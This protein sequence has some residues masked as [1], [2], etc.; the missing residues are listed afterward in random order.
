[1]IGVVREPQPGVDA[2]AYDDASSPPVDLL[3]PHY[4]VRVRQANGEWTDI[5]DRVTD[6]IHTDKG[7]G[8]ATSRVELPIN[9]FDDWAL[10]EEPILRKGARYLVQYGYPGRMREPAEFVAKEHKGNSK[11]ITVTAYER[12]RAKRSRQPKSR[13]WYE[14]TRSEVAREVLSGHGLD[15]SALHITETTERLASIT[16][17]KEHAWEFAEYLARLEGFELWSD[18][19]GI[20]WQEPKRS[21]A[22]AHL[23]RYVRGVVGVGL[24]KDYAIDSFGAGVAGRVVLYGRDPRT[25]RVYK[26]EGSDASTRGLVEVVDS[27]DIKTIAEGDQFDDGDTGFEI[28]RNIGSRTEQEAQLLADSLYK[29]YKYNA[30]KLNLTV[31]LEPTIRTFTNILVWGLNPSLDGIYSLRNATHRVGAKESVLQIRRAG[32]KKG[33]G[34]DAALDTALR[35]FLGTTSN[36]KPLSRLMKFLK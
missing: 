29:D 9:N 26:V 4:Y 24:I 1:M 25:K 2:S 11:S 8:G 13:T 14:K 28:E 5:T 23:F 12:K 32:R 17:A 27:D 6:V 10:R 7:G 15:P 34:S 31:F 35:N 22:P 20:Y 33:S 21:K 36:I 30:L 18:E 3:S 16:Q 19:G